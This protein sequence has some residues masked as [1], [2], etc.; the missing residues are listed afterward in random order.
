MHSNI[1]ATTHAAVL[2]ALIPYVIAV[3]RSW[4]PRAWQ[5][6]KRSLEVETSLPE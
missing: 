3:S 2:R 4:E 5:E 1:V 6:A